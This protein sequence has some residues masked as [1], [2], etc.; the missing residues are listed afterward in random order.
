H[1]LPRAA[2]PARPAVL[3]AVA[4]RPLVRVRPA[5]RRPRRVRR[6]RQDL[7]PGRALPPGGT[8][9]RLS[10]AQPPQVPAPR[11]AR[12][13]PRLQMA[14]RG[15]LVVRAVGKK[16]VPPLAPAVDRRQQP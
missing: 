16:A 14:R 12:P 5:W 3:A 2:E 1:A 9:R 6:L 7:G 15:P 8:A 4:L 13:G 11:R 10:G